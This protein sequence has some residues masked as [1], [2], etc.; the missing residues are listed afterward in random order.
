MAHSTVT[1]KR[2]TTIPG[3]VRKALRIKPGDR[4]EYAVEGDHATIQCISA[5]ARSRVCSPALEGI[6][7]DRK[8]VV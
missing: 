3:K 5:L 6:D 1:N 7:S 4:L 2:Q 8:S